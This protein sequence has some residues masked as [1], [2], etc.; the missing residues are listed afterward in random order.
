MGA[1]EQYL[2]SVRSVVA[3]LGTQLLSDRSGRLDSA[4]VATIAHQVAELRKKGFA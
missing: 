3:K 4:F 1:R 2:Q